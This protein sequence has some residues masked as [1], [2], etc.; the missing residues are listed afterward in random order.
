MI[1]L[2]V[3]LRA[4]A[5]TLFTT[6]FVFKSVQ[7]YISMQIRCSPQPAAHMRLIPHAHQDTT[8][9]Y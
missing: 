5:L 3:P 7:T 4:Y 9:E 1:K 8:E 6:R 2:N